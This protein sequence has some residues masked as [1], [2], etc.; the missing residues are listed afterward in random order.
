MKIKFAIPCLLTALLHTSLAFA[1][2]PKNTEEPA[3][4]PYAAALI[5]RAADVL[6]GAQN[7]SF[8]AEVWEDVAVEN[9]PVLQVSRTVDVR[10]RRPDRLV[11]EFSSDEPQRAF[12]FDGKALIVHDREAGFYGSVKTPATIDETITAAEEKFDITFPIED[13]LISKPFGDGAAKA[14]AGQHLGADKVLG[15]PC[16]HLAFQNENVDWEVW[17]EDGALPLV[18]KVVLRFKGGEK[19]GGILTAFFT[20]WDLTTAL[21]DAAFEFLAPPDAAKIELLSAESPDK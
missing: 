11:A 13:V 1:A 5:K 12:Y 15:V 8:S 19:E 20:K 14:K 2:D 4:A 18:R 6:G 7:V 9:G 16:Q 3:V 17:I 21:P 10:M